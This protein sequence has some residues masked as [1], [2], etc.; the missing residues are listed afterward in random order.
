MHFLEIFFNHWMALGDD[1]R[2]F[3]MCP[4]SDGHTEAI[5]NHFKDFLSSLWFPNA[6]CKAAKISGCIP[7]TLACAT[8]A[9]FTRLPQRPTGA[10]TRLIAFLLATR[11]VS[12]ITSAFSW[13]MSLF[14]K[15]TTHSLSGCI[16]WLVY[17]KHKRPKLYNLWSLFQCQ[18]Y[19][20]EISRT[21]L[22]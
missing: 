9:L 4:P 16:C 12:H 7:V 21:F 11:R 14:E 5:A 1:G 19:K 10:C 6:L 2:I 18:E 3:G 8:F 15:C 13:R 22:F 20:G 17:S